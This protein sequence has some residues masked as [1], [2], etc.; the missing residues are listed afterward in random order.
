VVILPAGRTL[1]VILFFPRSE[2]ITLADKEVVFD[3][4]GETL[5]VKSRFNLT[6]MVYKGR[7]DL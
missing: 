2:P 3:S 7:L 4:E 1:L 6:R 5:V